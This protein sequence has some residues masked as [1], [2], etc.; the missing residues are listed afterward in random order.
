MRDQNANLDR[1]YDAAIEEVED[2]SKSLQNLE[3]YLR[4]ET[5]ATEKEKTE[6][7][8]NRGESHMSLCESESSASQSKCGTL[9][10]RYHKTD[11][12]GS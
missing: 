7:E 5:I 6:G 11:S 3:E 4:S 1:L 10:K 12:F 9:V 8:E 2:L